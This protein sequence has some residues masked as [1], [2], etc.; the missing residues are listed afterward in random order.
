MPYYQLVR[1]IIKS[2]QISWNI[3]VNG[4]LK[5][6]IFVGR[7]NA[8]QRTR[9]SKAAVSGKEREPSEK[10]RRKWWS[11]S[12]PF[13]SIH[14]SLISMKRTFF[15]PDFEADFRVPKQTTIRPCTLE[16]RGRKTY[17]SN[18]RSCPW[19]LMSGILFRTSTKVKL[20]P[21]ARVWRGE[22]VGGRRKRAV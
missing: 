7:L 1:F 8:I 13:S 14:L 5:E 10:R 16:R 3:V 17:S 11:L 21:R 20:I 6:F 4:Q 15:G 22:N 12:P 9:P 19:F 2:V 18:G